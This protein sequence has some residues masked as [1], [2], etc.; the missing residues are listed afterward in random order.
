MNITFSD[1]AK[2]QFVKLDKPVQNQMRKFLDSL[3]N[4]QNPRTRGKELVGNRRGIW[5]YRV[6][7]YRILCQI[8]DKELCIFVV[9]VG[10]R[11]EVY[12]R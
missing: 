5:R 4:L 7:D 12:D 6:G 11:K 9:E 3:K 8:K 10:H 1:K 2:K